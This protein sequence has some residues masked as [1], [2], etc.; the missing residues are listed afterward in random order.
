MT[1]RYLSPLPVLSEIQAHSTVQWALQKNQSSPWPPHPSLSYI[2]SKS[3]FTLGPEE[4]FW[5]LLHPC[6]W[7]CYTCWALLT[8]ISS[9]AFSST[10]FLHVCASH[11]W[12]ITP[13]ASCHQASDLWPTELPWQPSPKGNPWLKFYRGPL[14]PIAHALRLHSTHLHLHSHAPICITP[15]YSS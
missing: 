9:L 1:P 4:S 13:I 14:M 12:P 10:A 3:I 5:R 2:D 8:P 7:P 15:L 6:L 11:I